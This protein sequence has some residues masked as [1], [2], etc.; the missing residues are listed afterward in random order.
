VRVPRTLTDVIDMH[1]EA[2]RDVK[3]YW[4]GAVIGFLAADMP[5]DFNDVYL[6]MIG[7]TTLGQPAIP[8][9]ALALVAMLPKDG[10]HPD[11]VL[12]ACGGLAGFK[13]ATA[14][15]PDADVCSA[16]DRRIFIESGPED[17]YHCPVHGYMHEPDCR[18]TLCDCTPENEFDMDSYYES[19]YGS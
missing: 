2:H 1:R 10:P 12:R 5:D 14:H 15:Y 17:L 18:Q 9:H 3:P 19:R 7:R 11:T 6:E 13:W 16:C 4:S 8:S